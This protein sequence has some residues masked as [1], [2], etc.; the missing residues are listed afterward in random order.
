MKTHLVALLQCVL[1]TKRTCTA[2][3]TMCVDTDT[4]T[5]IKDTDTGTQRPLVYLTNH[6]PILPCLFSFRSKL[7][8]VVAYVYLPLVL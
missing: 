1:A 6:C 8:F 7:F 2:T 3:D 4:D 5:D